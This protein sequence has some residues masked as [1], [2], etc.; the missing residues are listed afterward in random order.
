MIID[1]HNH[2]FPQAY[3]DAIA[4]GHFIPPHIG[5]MR[6]YRLVAVMGFLFET[7]IAAARLVYSGLFERLPD[8]KLVLAHLGGTIPFIAE[9]MVRGYEVYDECRVKLSRSPMATLKS[10]YMDTFPGTPEAIGTAVAF[11][12]AD[13]ILMGTDYPHQIGDLPG[14]VQTISQVAVTDAQKALILGEN[15]VRLN[16]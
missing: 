6:D 16:F 12:G 2:A 7:T 15:A 5:L 14:G 3:L 8:L 1:F 4:T 13:K 9:R 10:L 11:A